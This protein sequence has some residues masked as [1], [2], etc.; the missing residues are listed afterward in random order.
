MGLTDRLCKLIDIGLNK[1]RGATGSSLK[2]T[3]IYTEKLI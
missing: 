2:N 3:H 1:K